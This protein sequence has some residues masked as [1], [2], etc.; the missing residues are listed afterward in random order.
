MAT[1]PMAQ[2]VHT[3][4][5]MRI[6]LLG[7]LSVEDGFSEPPIK[8]PYKSQ[9]CYQNPM[10]NRMPVFNEDQRSYQNNM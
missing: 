8:A 2:A 1:V 6:P 9:G 4:Y 5:S 7:L 10:S 3:Y